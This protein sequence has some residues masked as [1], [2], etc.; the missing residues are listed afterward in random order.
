MNTDGDSRNARL[1]RIEAAI[2]RG[3]AETA[4]LKKLIESNAKAIEANSAAIADNN[5]QIDVLA[6][7]SGRTLR[8]VDSLREIV[9]EERVNFREYRERTDTNLVSLNAA[10]ERLETIVAYLVR[11]DRDNP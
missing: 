8:A 11:K 7:V 3:Q 2:E 5:Q 4:A 6:E 9:E 10:V 1:D